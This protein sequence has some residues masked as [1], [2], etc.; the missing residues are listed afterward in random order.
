ML[1]SW[2]CGVGSIWDTNHYLPGSLLKLTEFCPHLL[3]SVPALADLKWKHWAISCNSRRGENFFK[4][5]FCVY[6]DFITSLYMLYLINH[7]LPIFFLPQVVSVPF[8]LYISLLPLP[9]YMCS[10]S[11]R[12]SFF[13][14]FACEPRL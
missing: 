3:S 9:P 2:V 8:C 11:S 7:L 5:C 13:L 6:E 14:K 4:V 1:G 12:I 10:S